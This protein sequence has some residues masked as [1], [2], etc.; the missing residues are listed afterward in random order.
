MCW[1][2]L[3]GDVSSMLLFGVILASRSI[4][5]SLS[6]LLLEGFTYGSTLLI[7]AIIVDGH[8]FAMWVSLAIGLNLWHFECFHVDWF[9][10]LAF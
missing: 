2:T 5:Y 9:E 10:S 3:N 8:T 4:F 1:H 6:R 7:S